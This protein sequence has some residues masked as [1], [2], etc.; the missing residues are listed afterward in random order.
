MALV[1]LNPWNETT[2]Y[3]PIQNESIYNRKII[4]KKK[5]IVRENTLSNRKLKQKPEREGTIRSKVTWPCGSICQIR[6]VWST[7]PEASFVPMQFQATE[8]TFLKR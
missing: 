1:S 2:G 8:C 4:E 6:A 5:K 7:E 3:F